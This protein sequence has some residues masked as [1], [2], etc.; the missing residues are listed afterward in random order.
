MRRLGVLGNDFIRKL[1]LF[2]S[3]P[4]RCLQKSCYVLPRLAMAQSQILKKDICTDNAAIL[5]EKPCH[6]PKLCRE[7]ISQFAAV[8]TCFLINLL[9]IATDK[10]G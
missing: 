4:R 8:S 1:L 6:R 2:H 9:P 3:N 7:L 5:K 10:N